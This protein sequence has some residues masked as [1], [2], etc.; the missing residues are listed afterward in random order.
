MPEPASGSESRC[1]DAGKAPADAAQGAK[2]KGKY[3]CVDA[4]E[5]EG[6]YEIKTWW[7]TIDD[8][9]AWT[10]SD[11]FRQAHANRPPKEMFRGPSEITVHEI[12]T[13]TDL[14]PVADLID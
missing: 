8:F 12:V 3:P 4:P 14:D 5:I 9:I 13:S 6:Y 10:R 7:K 2:R 11:S 1:G